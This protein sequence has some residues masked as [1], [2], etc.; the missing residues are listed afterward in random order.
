MERPSRP[1]PYRSNPAPA[2]STVLPMSFVLT[3]ALAGAGLAAPPPELRKVHAL[4]VIDTLSGL[5]ESVKVDGERIDH[6]LSE[7]IPADRIEIRVL[8][9]KDVN[10][11]GILAYYRNL[12]ADRND[13]IFFYYAGHG[14]TDPRQ[15]HFLAVQDLA[16]KPLIRSELRKAMLQHHPALTVIMTDCCSNVVPLGK[17]RRVLID[18]G[19]AQTLD[20]LLRCLLFQLRGLVDITAASGNASFGDDHEGG[21][22][23]RT[24]GGLIEKGIDGSDTDGDGFVSWN[25]FFKRLQTSTASVFVTW[26]DKQRARGEDVDQSSQKPMAFS[27]GGK[28]ELRAVLIRNGRSESII[29]EFRWSGRSSWSNGRIAPGG[30]AEHTVPADLSDPEPSLEVRF[31]EGKTVKL[32]VRKPYYF[33][34]KP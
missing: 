13:A 23:T 1:R 19:N 31:A 25:E 33:H 5:G 21:I 6:L 2:S 26:A 20:P 24:F 12:Q 4:L 11:D 18:N 30:H 17:T 7:R 22:F 28:T 29:Y 34:D 27:L 14:A 3:L 8:T 16:S 9:G 32:G 15:G 10:A